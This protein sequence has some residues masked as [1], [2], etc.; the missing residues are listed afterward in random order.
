MYCFYYQIN[1][2]KIY[3]HQTCHQKN[4]DDKFDDK[5]KFLEK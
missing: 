4:S 5:T 2:G 3:S 1:T